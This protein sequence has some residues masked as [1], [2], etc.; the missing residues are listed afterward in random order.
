[1]LLTGIGEG[2]FARAQSAKHHAKLGAGLQQLFQRQRLIHLA[3]KLLWIHVVVLH[4]AADGH[5]KPTDTLNDVGLYLDTPA[6]RSATDFTPDDRKSS[7]IPLSEQYVRELGRR[8]WHWI[9]VP[10]ELKWSATSAFY[11]ESSS[12]KTEGKKKAGMRGGRAGA[13]LDGCQPVGESVT[14]Q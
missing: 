10:V 1:M 8:S 6:S 3:I 5:N 14:Q 9:V 7:R 11:A 12:S 13:G 2:P 4:K